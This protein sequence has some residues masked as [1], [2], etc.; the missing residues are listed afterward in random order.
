[1]MATTLS[2]T[3]FG[4]SPPPLSL[5][6][7][8]FTIFFIMMSLTVFAY[9]IKELTQYELT[10]NIYEKFKQKKENDR[11]IQRECIDLWFWS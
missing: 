11:C 8:I 4:E 9:W 6:A 3:G 2:T 1:M 5:T 10:E 7:K